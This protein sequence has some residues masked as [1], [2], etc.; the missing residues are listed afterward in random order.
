M[1]I[2][3]DR[4][5]EGRLAAAT[6]K[7]TEVAGQARE[8]AGQAFGTAVERAGDVYA[9]AR[10]TAGDTL[11][12][13]RDKA[14]DAIATARDGATDTLAL[15]RGKAGDAY[16]AARERALTATKATSEGVQANPVV[17]LI[18]GLA[19]GIVAGTLLP[20]SEGEAKLLAPLGSRLI[21]LAKLA[22]VAAKDAGLG[23]LGDA[24]INR[25]AAKA[26]IDKLLDTTLGAAKAAGGA[27]ADAVRKP[28][29]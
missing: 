13:V 18:G 3:S 20:R 28:A 8:V 2:P 19:V 9:S 11:S 16:S 21:D 29:E 5:D 6:A 7:I 12:I 23:A 10:D 25:D 17:A 4:D 24:G 27:A 22:A 14:G 26:Q 1:T 15:V